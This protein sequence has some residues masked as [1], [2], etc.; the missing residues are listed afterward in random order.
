VIGAGM[1]AGY[2]L[3]GLAAVPMAVVR[4]IVGRR[5][6]ATRAL[7]DRHGIAEAGVDI[8]AALARADV[9]AVVITTPD[10]THADIAMR[11]AAAGKA[12]LLQKP[13]ARDRPEAERVVLAARAAGVDLQV[14]FMH[15]YFEEV[16]EAQRLLADG[17][18]GRVTALRLRNATPG[19]DWGDWFFKRDRVAGGVVPQLG[20]HGIDLVG[21]LAGPITG[22][23]ARTATLVAARRLADGREVAVENPDSAWAIYDLASGA[24]ACHEMSMI[25]P[26]GTDRFRLEIQGTEGVMW[27]RAE[28]GRLVWRRPGDA[29]WRRVDPPDPPPGQRQHQTWIDG[30]TGRA[31]P[32]TTAADALQGMAVVDA[33]QR[34]ADRGGLRVA[35]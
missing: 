24:V 31:P 18:I 34:S 30:L 29:D 12:I 5:P 25:E 14:S 9:D 2:H 3:G 22:V 7:A 4:V 1:I 19:P 21:L 13:M 32:E 27:L 10:D 15:R 35:P 33:I 8:D 17:A 16:I 26:A 28:P 11:A 6:E 20:V 23:S